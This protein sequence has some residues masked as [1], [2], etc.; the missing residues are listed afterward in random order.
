MASSSSSSSA[1]S[2]SSQHWR[3]PVKTPA[4]NRRLQ[5]AKTTQDNRQVD[6]S[7]SALLHRIPGYSLAA[8]YCSAEKVCEDSGWDIP[9]TYVISGKG[10]LDHGPLRKML[11]SLGF[12]ERTIEAVV[13]SPESDRYVGILF[14][15]QDSTVFDPKTSKLTCFI[16]SILSNSK[17]CITDKRLLY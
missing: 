14:L 11:D 9:L 10:G 4:T 16:K 8:E 5:F 2:S 3:R 15:E 17:R 13:E 1:S 7:R 6:R 12:T